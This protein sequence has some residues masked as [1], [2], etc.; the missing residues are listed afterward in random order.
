M[1]VITFAGPTVS[2]ADFASLF[3]QTFNGSYTAYANILDIVPM[4]SNNIAGMGSLYFKG[5]N[6][7][8]PRASEIYFSSHPY[9]SLQA[10]FDA[11]AVTI[12]S[13]Q[14]YEGSWYTPL[15]EITQLN[16]DSQII[17]NDCIGF[18]AW[19]EQA[20]DQHGSDN[21]LQLMGLD[22]I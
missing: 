4:A 10:F 17:P 19:M 13:A 3:S 16:T 18:E 21:Y 9:L 14:E 2:N 8:N 1:N 12:W 22:P 11:A 15:G 20:G 5:D 7:D 6:S